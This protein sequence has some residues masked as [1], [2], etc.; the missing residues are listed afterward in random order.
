[1]VWQDCETRLNHGLV[2][3]PNDAVHNVGNSRMRRD[4]ESG[5]AVQPVRSTIYESVITLLKVVSRDVHSR[6]G[7]LAEQRQAHPQRPNARR[8]VSNCSTGNSMSKETHTRPTYDP[9]RTTT[10]FKGCSILIGRAVIEISE[11]VG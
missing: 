6:G 4:G 8:V 1:M 2:R 10:F 9:P 5:C 11:V 3:N 7:M